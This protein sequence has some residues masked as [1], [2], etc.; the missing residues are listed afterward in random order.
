MSL[1][2][3]T[4]PTINDDES[5]L[6]SVIT[7]GM[8][9]DKALSQPQEQAPSGE[10]QQPPI[11]EA[12]FGRGKRKIRRIQA[13]KY[14]EDSLKRVEV[15]AASITENFDAMALAKLA[16]EMV[17][18][19]K[20]ALLQV[21]EV[22]KDE[23]TVGEPISM[24]NDTATTEQIP[25]AVVAK[26]SLKKTSAPTQK[27]TVQQTAKPKT[28]VVTTEN[29]WVEVAKKR[30][31]GARKDTVTLLEPVAADSEMDTV[32][33]H[34]ETDIKLLTREPRLPQHHEITVL[35]FTNMSSRK[36]VPAK[37]WREKL[38][39][40]QIKIHSIVF[41]S[42]G[43]IE[44]VAPKD[45]EI[46]LRKFFKG[47]NRTPEANICPFT[48]QSTKEPPSLESVIQITKNR[49]Q[50]M[51]HERSIVALR[52]ME[53]CVQKGIRLAG[54]FKGEQLKVE[55]QAAKKILKI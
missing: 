42:W 50:M 51:L 55:L 53:Q 4:I 21:L 6:V 7:E 1:A 9:D 37:K 52:Y 35:K 29:P 40:N 16:L 34:P 47:L 3:V 24:G 41:P 22:F 11:E 15:R 46:K 13:Y 28:K 33:L 44:I 18:E 26:K 27:Q 20:G 8:T 45:E 30:L 54:V 25:Q 38:R 48:P 49:I 10:I 12:E 31:L 19:V 32:P 39:E 36:D 2:A 23:V 5:T 17:K 43:T 14:A